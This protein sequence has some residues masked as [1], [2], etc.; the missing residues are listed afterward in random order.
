VFWGHDTSE[1]LLALNDEGDKRLRKVIRDYSDVVMRSLKTTTEVL[2]QY[3]PRVFQVRIQTHTS[4]GQS[5]LC[6]ILFFF[7][8]A[9]GHEHR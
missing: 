6:D 4:C 8:G 7:S 9:H 2:S 1:P 5:I 3:I